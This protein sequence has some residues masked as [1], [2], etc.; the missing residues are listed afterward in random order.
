MAVLADDVQ[1]F[2]SEPHLAVFVTL[3]KDGS[4]QATPVWV[5]HDGD[6][7]LINTVKGHLKERNLQRDRRVTVC[8]VDR[9]VAGRYLQVRGRVAA[10]IEDE[11]AFQHINELSQKYSGRPYPLRDGEQR[12]KVVIEPEHV[13]YQGGRG[14]GRWAAR[15]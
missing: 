12:V 13:S 7:V 10:L 1:Q 2:L 14:S 5:H 11:E 8:V 4:P 9:G 15:D 6:H 3:M